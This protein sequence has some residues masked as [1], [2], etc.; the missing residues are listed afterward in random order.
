MASI[1]VKFSSFSPNLHSAKAREDFFNVYSV[2][3]LAKGLLASGFG[4]ASDIR[5]NQQ[6]GR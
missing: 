3:V 4:I 6:E 1:F 5:I 2:S